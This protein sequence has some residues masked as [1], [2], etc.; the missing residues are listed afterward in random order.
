MTC[1][2]VDKQVSKRGVF[3]VD[4][5]ESGGGCSGFMARDCPMMQPG[6]QPGPAQTHAPAIWASIATRSD[7][8]ALAIT[9]PPGRRFR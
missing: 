2:G 9:Q 5:G 4:E 7:G 3:G 1:A 6:F 8:A